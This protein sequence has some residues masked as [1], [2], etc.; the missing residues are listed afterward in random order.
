MAGS[1]V[2]DNKGPLKDI[3]DVYSM[4]IKNFKLLKYSW[5]LIATICILALVAFYKLQNKDVFLYAL[6]VIFI[7]FIG[8]LLSTLQAQNDKFKKALINVLIA[9]LTITMSVAILSFG[10]FIIWGQPEL[11]KNVFPSVNS[12]SVDTTYSEALNTAKRDTISSD[13]GSIA[14]KA[15]QKADNTPTNQE[16]TKL[17]DLPKADINKEN[18]KKVSRG[19]KRIAKMH[20]DTMTNIQG[21][22]TENSQAIKGATIYYQGAKVATSNETG[23]FRIQIYG[24]KQDNILI[25]IN[26]KQKN[27]RKRVGIFQTDVTV[28][29]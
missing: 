3:L 24:V 15:N 2:G 12:P 25:D 17:S 4:A 18:V 26:W 21:H 14:N 8:F 23:F 16:L 29:L 27:A 11:Y 22:V 1:E 10:S 20:L 28:K 5:V 9:S 13:S 7:S 6:A 19:A